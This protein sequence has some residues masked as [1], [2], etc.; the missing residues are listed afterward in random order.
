MYFDS[1]LSLPFVLREWACS[2]KN[3]NSS[4]SGS[5]SSKRWWFLPVWYSTILLELGT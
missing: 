1:S 4:N 2:R 3:S 5:N